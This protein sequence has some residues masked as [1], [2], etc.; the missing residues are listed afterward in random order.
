MSLLVPLLYVT[1]LS[2]TCSCCC[3][4]HT[5]CS[6]SIVPFLLPPCRDDVRAVYLGS[7]GLLRSAQSVLVAGLCKLNGF[8]NAIALTSLVSL[9]FSCAWQPVHR[10]QYYRPTNIHSRRTGRRRE[11]LCLCRCPGFWR[12]LMIALCHCILISHAYVCTQQQIWVT[13]IMLRARSAP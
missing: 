5:Q 2:I 3:V 11:R 7:G 12:Y 6:P 13:R 8:L 4:I 10:L 9:Q 1:E